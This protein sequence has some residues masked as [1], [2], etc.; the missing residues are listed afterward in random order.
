[1]RKRVS[2]ATILTVCVAVFAM[3]LTATARA[4]DA[5]YVEYGFSFQPP[6]G[7]Q[8]DAEAEGPIRVQ[9][10]GPQ[11]GDGSQ[12]RLNLSVQNYA[13]NLSDQQINSL[14]TEMLANINELGM[15]DSKVIS[16]GKTTIA[17]HD[18]LQ[19]DYS[20]NQDGAPIR[21][22]Q[23]YIP[24]GDHKRTYLFTFVDNAQH[25]EQSAGAVQAAISS[26]TSAQASSSPAT[27][28]PEP[29]QGASSWEWLL[30]IIGIIALCAVAGA[31]YLLMRRKA[32]A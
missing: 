23:V 15:R 1:M 22:R 32:I 3:L 4:Q 18:A 28:T 10:F 13:I 24:V 14:S 5:R 26:F 11:R 7:W 30:I 6:A 19:I 31:A 16:H 25:F 8:Q 12:P 17:G 9:Y 20:Y 2:L 27:A 29:E 21:L